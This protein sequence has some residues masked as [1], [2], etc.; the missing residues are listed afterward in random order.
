MHDVEPISV[1]D[2]QRK[3]PGKDTL[4]SL[5]HQ[6]NPRLFNAS[7]WKA[8]ERLV[9]WAISLYHTYIASGWRAKECLVIW[10]ISPLNNS[11][12][13]SSDQFEGKRWK[14]MKMVK[15]VYSANTVK[16]TDSV[17]RKYGSHW[18]IPWLD[19]EA[20][21]KAELP[22]ATACP[23]LKGLSRSLSLVIGYIF[24]YTCI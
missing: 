5:T 22:F 9:I 1:W 17:F 4:A 12:N 24:I 15:S 19:R 7:R 20:W 6:S 21:T 18:L 11:N 14:N 2:A 10:A 23:Y 3:Y 13:A 8:M 16:A